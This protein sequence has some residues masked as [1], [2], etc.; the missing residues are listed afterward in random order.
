VAAGAPQSRQPWWRA[1][2]DGLGSTI[3]PWVASQYP[4]GE[5]FDSRSVFDTIWGKAPERRCRMAELARPVERDIRCIR[6]GHNDLLTAVVA[7]DYLWPVASCL[8][9]PCPGCG[10]SGIWEWVG[11]AREAHR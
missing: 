5:L 2:S 10:E 9:T 7:P 4:L 3:S 6:C 1:C 8:D 11:E